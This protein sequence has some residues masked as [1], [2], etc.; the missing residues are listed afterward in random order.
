[1]SVTSDFLPNR[2]KASRAARHLEDGR[3]AAAASLF[4]NPRLNSFK[5]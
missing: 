4:F 1:M 5:I 3:P 2:T